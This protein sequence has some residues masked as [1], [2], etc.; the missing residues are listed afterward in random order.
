K[1]AESILTGPDTPNERVRLH[2]SRGCSS[3]RG[4]CQGGQSMKRVMMALVLAACAGM[5]CESLPRLWEHPKP[6]VPASADVKPARPPLVTA[7]QVNDGNARQ[8]AEALL[9]EMD[10]DAQGT[11]ISDQHEKPAH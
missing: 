3:Q 8:I 7:E 11:V 1:I 5:G 6:V 10:R 9:D 2:G 4:C